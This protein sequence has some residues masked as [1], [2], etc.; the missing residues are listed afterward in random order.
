MAGRCDSF[1][2]RTVVDDFFNSEPRDGFFLL[3]LLLLGFFGWPIEASVY[4]VLY[5][6]FIWLYR[7]AEINIRNE[8]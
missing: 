3:L 8:K 6:Y 4:T 7:R 1:F 2:V 5:F